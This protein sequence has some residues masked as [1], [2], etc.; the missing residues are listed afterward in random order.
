MELNVIEK[1]VTKF[2]LDRFFNSKLILA[3]DLFVS[4]SASV[5][6]LMF[7]RLLLSDEGL[8]TSFFLTWLGLSFVLS[9]VFF[10]I[11]KTYRTII[12][13]TTLKEFAK[14]GV[15][16]FLKSVLVGAIM[17]ALPF[18][19]D[20]YYAVLTAMDMCLTIVFLLMVRVIMIVAYDALRSP[21]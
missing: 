1:F 17:F 7:V 13:H 4:F 5:C 21:L 9:L 2:H 20:T 19:A 14:I 18:F 8:T 12:R 11:F 3:I 10:I 16:S 15:A 6:T